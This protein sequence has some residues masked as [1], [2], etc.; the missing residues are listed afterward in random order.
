MPSSFLQRKIS[1]THI[2][3]NAL[4][5]IKRITRTATPGEVI[6]VF[7]MGDGKDQTLVFSPEVDL[8]S[9]DED[10]LLHQVAI[11]LQTKQEKA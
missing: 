6:V 10:E 11:F 2:G 9:V 5:Y 3:G 7:F 8:D 1:P 4:T